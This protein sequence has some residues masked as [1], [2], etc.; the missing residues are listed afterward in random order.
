MSDKGK[1]ILFLGNGVNRVAG[2]NE[3]YSWS[4]ALRHLEDNMVP[5]PFR[6]VP[7]DSEDNH[8]SYVL[9][10][11][12]V[13]NFRDMSITASDAWEKWLDE[14]KAL[15]PTFVHHLL[16]ELVNQKQFS[17]VITTNYDFAMERA[18]LPGFNPEE[19]EPCKETPSHYKLNEAVSIWHLHGDALQK[20]RVVMSMKS[21]RDI[22]HETI[23]A[24]PEPNWLASFCESEMHVCGFS[25]EPEESLIWYALERRF[26]KLQKLPH[27]SEL[28]NRFYIY[29]FYTPEN[30][31]KQR[32]LAEILSSY[33]TQ[34]MLIPVPIAADGTPDYGSA[35]LQVYARMKMILGKIRFDHGD[36][37][38]MG[39]QKHAF[40]ESRDR[41]LTTAYTVSCKYP[42]FCK[43]AL[44]DAKRELADTWCFYCEIERHSYM[45]SV[46]VKSIMEGIS[47]MHGAA[48]RNRDK[49]Y[50]FYLNFADGILY[51]C[52]QNSTSAAE[53][54]TVC[55]LNRLESIDEFES[56]IVKI[57]TSK[58]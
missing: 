6:S 15:A 10:L 41:N 53:L 32:C 29:L 34:P 9:R 40:L 46:P 2:R 36:S 20:D 1:R 35:W 42:Q 16:A 11:Q 24:E 7:W 57:S 14:V 23:A 58:H 31:Q 13:L 5:E 17:K 22:L 56:L 25:F 12:R 45:W 43:V 49:G 30:E 3:A 50:D 28:Q 48:F 55:N 26:E 19:N 54:Y 38:V 51:S 4:N 18:I 39:A 47:K 21:Y 44:P 52:H 33:A 8:L 27:F 37:I